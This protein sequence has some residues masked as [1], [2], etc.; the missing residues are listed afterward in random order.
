MMPYQ[1]CQLWDTARARA[2]S[3]RRAADER[4]GQLAAAIS[5]SFNQARHRVRG[6]GPA[7]TARTFCSAS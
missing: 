6:G 3:D 1:S 2:A 5:G 7:I 4:L